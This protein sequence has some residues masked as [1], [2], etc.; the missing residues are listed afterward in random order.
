MADDLGTMVRE[1]MNEVRISDSVNITTCVFDAIDHYATERFFFNQFRD[2]TFSLSSSQEYY[3]S[4]DNSMIPRVMELDKLTMTVSS[5]DKRTLEKW[6]WNYIEDINAEATSGEP[7]AYAYWGQQIRF[8]P[9][10]NSGYEVR[11]AGVFQAPTLSVST[12]SNC[13]TIRSQGKELIKQRAK[14]IYY[15]E[16][17]R[18]DVLAG[19]AEKREAQALDRL[20]ART[21]QLHQT[22]DVTPWL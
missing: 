5:N 10:P 9:T 16:F 17:R 18:D 7:F 2:Q 3:T 1:I 21:T 12:D 15:S 22:G 19:R 4:A 6:S 8:Y 11:M 13:W 14:S 20:R